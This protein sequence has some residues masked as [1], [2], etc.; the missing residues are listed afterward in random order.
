METKQI[1][2]ILLIIAI[3]FLITALVLIFINGFDFN[4]F[5]IKQT[6]GTNYIVERIVQKPQGASVGITIVGSEG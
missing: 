2:I 1:A 4:D 3:I 6:K 5:T